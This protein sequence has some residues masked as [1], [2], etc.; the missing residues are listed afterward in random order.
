VPAEAKREA[1]MRGGYT[2]GSRS[3]VLPE[4]LTPELRNPEDVTRLLQETAGQVRRGELSTQVGNA[5]GYLCSVSLRSFELDVL[6]RVEK[7]RDAM[8]EIQRPTVVPARVVE[9]RRVIPEV[10]GNESG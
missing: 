8:S 6:R 9:A 10:T 3:I 5:I 2:A 7:L 1:V 4:A